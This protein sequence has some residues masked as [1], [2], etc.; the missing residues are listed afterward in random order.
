M[1][2]ISPVIA[3]ARALLIGED[4]MP[5]PA[6]GLMLLGT[7]AAAGDAAAAALL[8]TLHTSGAWAP[9]DWDRGLD[10]LQRAAELG[11]AS[12]QGQLRLLAPG[13]GDWA[14]RRHAVDVAAWLTPPP[15]GN[16]CQSPRVRQ[17]DDFIA[18]EVCDWLIGL[19]QGRLKPAMMV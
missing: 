2:E 6:Q 5:D 19:T 12:A 4:R 9:Q 7:A 16:L 10:L 3:S 14:E 15:R 17:C 11:S 8:A 1:T 13:G 18:P